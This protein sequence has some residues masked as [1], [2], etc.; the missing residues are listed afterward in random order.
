M[1]LCEGTGGREREG[2][3]V[4]IFCRKVLVPAMLEL[5][6]DFTLGE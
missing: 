2:R 1:K 4:L 5:S 6:G 3:L